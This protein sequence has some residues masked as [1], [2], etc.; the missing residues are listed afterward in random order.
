MTSGQRWNLC[1]SHKHR[2]SRQIRKPC[3]KTDQWDD[4]QH[5]SCRL[6]SF[7]RS[8]WARKVRTNLALADL[9]KLCQESKEL[10][11]QTGGTQ[12]TMEVFCHQKCQSKTIAY[13]IIIFLTNIQIWTPF[14]TDQYPDVWTIS[15][16]NIMPLKEKLPSSRSLRSAWKSKRIESCTENSETNGQF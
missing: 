10:E 12:I 1:F 13:F 2:A 3:G 9:E 5:N 14:A 4:W 11:K 8:R 7:Q 16:S 15:S 6:E